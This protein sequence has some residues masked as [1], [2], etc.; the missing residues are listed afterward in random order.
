MEHAKSGNI[1]LHEEKLPYRKS[2]I[3]AQSDVYHNTSVLRLEDFATEETAEK[4]QL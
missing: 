2:C 4:Y 3:Y 1:A